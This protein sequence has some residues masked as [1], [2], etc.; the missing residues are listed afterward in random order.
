[1]NTDAGDHPLLELVELAHV[2]EGRLADARLGV[3]RGDLSDLGLRLLQQL[4]KTRHDNS[5]GPRGW[6]VG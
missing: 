5:T 4:A 2:E 6:S 1:M 3:G